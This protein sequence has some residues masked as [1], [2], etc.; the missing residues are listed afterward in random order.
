L[1]CC[2]K[3]LL[4]AG[5]AL[6]PIQAAFCQH[7]SDDPVASADDAFG[8]TQGLESIGLYSPGSI[9]GFNPQTAGNVRVDGLYFDQQGGLS[10]RV[11]EGS[12]IRVGI[13]ETGYAFPAPTGI[14]D[15]DLRHAGDGTPSGSIVATVGPFQGQ[16]FSA[17]GVLPI[18][19]S[20]LQLPIGISDQLSM[21][22][23]WVGSE[24]PGY[25]S[26]YKNF[27]AAPIW[28]PND[29][30]TIRLLVDWS[31][32]TQA[33]TAPQ[34]YT[35]GDFLPPPVARGYYGQDWAEG[36]SV[37]KNLGAIA[38]LKLSTNW[39]FSAGFFRSTY[40]VPLSFAD[41]Y[42]NTERNGSADRAFVANPDQ[43]VASN[44]GE[45]RLTG[46]FG[47]G[48]VRQSVIFSARGRDTLSY[49]GGSDLVNLG[50]TQLG[51]LLSLPEPNFQFTERTRDQ[52]R[53]WSTGV[54]YRVQWQQHGDLEFGIQHEDY[55]KTVDSPGLSQT[56]LKDSPLRGYLQ[57]ALILSDNL[58]AYA[59]YT[60]GLED[61]GTAPSGAAN[62]GAILPDARTWQ[63]DAGVQLKL[64]E[65]L[66]LIAGVFEIE[67]PYFNFDNDE[68][69]RKLGLQRAEG[70]ETSISGELLKN[71]NVTAGGLFGSVRI[72]GPDLK[73]EGVG[74]I[75]FGQPRVQ[76]TVSLDYKFQ[77]LPKLSTDLTVIY[78]GHTPASVD[79][80]VQNPAQTLLFLGG[81]YRFELLGKAATLRV[82]LQNAT[83]LYFWNTGFSPG[84]SQYQ[85]RSL[86]SYLT[87][88]L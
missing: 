72:L 27:G 20:E 32:L 29:R 63:D 10:N 39:S 49:Y 14:V 82:Q 19:S 35:A 6:L 13:S 87:V 76:G 86:F 41:L 47:S 61:S 4:A 79:N 33:K 18:G 64:S 30:V 66:K 60:Q 5:L 3:A 48:A 23:N 11:V 46:D 50:P 7:A 26:R 80:V 37:S 88:D 65:K 24:I 45:M 70:V 16:R 43:S 21:G 17:D 28:H 73:A 67:K 8:L 42:L 85:P 53:M 15:Y 36:E 9:R 38:H 52:T 57:G 81:R 31:Q 71:L 69:D 84:F 62:R 78:F 74:P 1:R 56:Q 58:T 44:S 25:T 75:A 12:T 55:Q 2:T 59:G 77:S 54:G 68:V 34:V 51:E 40:D 22:G 83:N